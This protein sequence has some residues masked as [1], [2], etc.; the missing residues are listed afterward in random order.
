MNALNAGRRLDVDSFR[1]AG[2]GDRA[3]RCRRTA[4]DGSPL[5]QR[6]LPHRLRGPRRDARARRPPRRV[7]RGRRSQNNATAN[8]FFANP[9]NDVAPAFAPLRP[10]ADAR[11]KA[12]APIRDD[13]NGARERRLERHPSRGSGWSERFLGGPNR[14]VHQRRRPHLARRRRLLLA[15]MAGGWWHVRRLHRHALS[16]AASRWQTACRRIAYRLGLPAA[17]HV[18]ES[19]R[20]DVPTVVGWL[21]PA[22]LLPIAAMAT[23]TPA[24]VEAILAHELAHIRRHDY[25]CQPAADRR[26]DAAS[27]IT[28]R[29]GGSR[30]GFAPSASTAAMKWR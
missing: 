23:L 10:S 27:S 13:R 6:P 29:C 1:V 26:R 18:V 25:A 19:A 20:V 5:A 14:S 22:I 3:C 12:R 11:L 16:T 15:R 28:P 21:R 17:A 7:S 9:A 8:E 30:S 2:D 4:L 24:Q